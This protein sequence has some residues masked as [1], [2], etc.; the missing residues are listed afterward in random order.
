MVSTGVT[1]IFALILMRNASGIDIVGFAPVSLPVWQSAVLSAVVG[2][3]TA[4]ASRGRRVPF[5]KHF[6]VTGPADPQRVNGLVDALE[7]RRREKLLEER[8]R[9]V[10]RLRIVD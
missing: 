2:T 9:A 8:R 10:A 3:G 5:R 4:I 1:G 6:R 7:P